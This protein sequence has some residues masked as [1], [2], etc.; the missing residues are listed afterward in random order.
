MFSPSLSSFYLPTCGN[1]SFCVL[2]MLLIKIELLHLWF[3][4]SLFWPTRL[5]SIKTFLC[6]DS[7]VGSLFLIN[8][9]I[10]TYVYAQIN[11]YNVYV[12]I[13]ICTYTHIHIFLS[14]FLLLLFML[15]STHHFYFELIR[16][17]IQI[18]HKALFIY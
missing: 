18:F 4:F 3:L 10:H 9:V 14:L 13:H 5:P 15:E 16:I 6:P 11:I 17:S 2:I 8:I 1:H 12:H 7:K